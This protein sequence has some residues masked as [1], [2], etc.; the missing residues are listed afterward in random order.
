M[1]L[2]GMKARNSRSMCTNLTE[3]DMVFGG[4]DKLEQSIRDA[5]ERHHPKI[6]FIS[7]SCATGIIGDDIDSAVARLQKELGAT[8]IPLHCEG[9]RSKHFSSGFDIVPH[10]IL[11]QLVKPSEQKQEDLVNVL[12]LWGEDVFTSMFKRLG[13]R[14][15][16]VIAAASIDDLEQLSSAAATVSMC[17]TLSYMATA[18]EQ[19]F[20]VPEIKAPLPYGFAGTD[21]WLR[22]LGRVTHREEQVE[23]YIRE[24]HE[25]CVPLL[26]E[27]RYKLQGRRGFVATGGTFAHALIGVLCELGI[28]VNG[29]V[30]YHHDLVYDSNDPQQDTLAHMVNTYGDVPNFTVSNYQHFQLLATL[31]R[32]KPD[33]A[34]IRHGGMAVLASRLGIPALPMVD[35]D[36]V[37]GYQGILNLGEAILNILPNRVFYEEI[38][39]HTQLPYKEEWLK[40]TDPMALTIKDDDKSMGD[41]GE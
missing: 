14:P 38:A 40:Q 22:E 3:D 28:E 25:R 33:F 24:E 5:W 29:S 13:L 8:I 30:A 21:T 9:F 16:L 36:Y 20:G 34:I 2:H 17:Y 4:I 32:T 11:R 6:I 12:Y 7:S 27:L 10:G 41:G 26:E 19:E 31:Q 39:A 1:S 15:N 23:V 37:L 18:L 35:P